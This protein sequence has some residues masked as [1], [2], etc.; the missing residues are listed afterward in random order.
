LPQAGHLAE[1]VPQA[2]HVT[3]VSPQLPPRIAT[4][5]RG[6]EPVQRAWAE[7]A[8]MDVANAPPQ[9]HRV[10][11]T[12]GQPL[13]HGVRSRFEGLLG[14][15]LTGVRVH[16][17]ESAA[18][19]ASAVGAKAFTVNHQVVFG[20]DQLRP[21]APA[22]NSLLAHEL[23][24][25]VQQRTA[26]PTARPV[27]QRQSDDDRAES[28]AREKAATQQRKQERAT[29]GKDFDQLTARDAENELRELEHS[30]QQPGAQQ[31][32]VARKDADLEQFRKLLTRVPGS[33]LEKSKRQGAFSELQRTP[34]T[35]AGTPQDKYVAGGPQTK[36]Q[37]LRAGRDS[38]AQP[39]WSLWR[40]RPDGSVERIHV[41]LKSDNLNSL[42]RGQARG[43][44]RAYLDQA[45][46]NS[47]HLADGEG[48]VIHFTQTPS[49]EIQA[50]MNAILFSAGSP[51][52]EVRYGTTT[53]YRPAPRAGTTSTTPS[54]A[55]PR[56][57][58]RAR[59]T[60]PKRAAKAA[61]AKKAATPKPKP[62]AATEKPATSR[63]A[64]AA[65][66]TTQ[67]PAKVAPAEPTAKAAKATTQE[68]AKVAPAEPTAKAAAHPSETQA[69]TPTQ[70]QSIQNSTET[71][72]PA[73]TP[74]K[75][76]P[77]VTPAPVQATET[78]TPTL[79]PETTEA[80]VGSPAPGIKAGGGLK[81][82][83]KAGGKALGWALLF[84]A[85][86]YEAWQ[87]REVAMEADRQ[88]ILLHIHGSSG[89]AT[90]M[91]KQDPSKPVYITWT[92][93][94]E[95]YVHYYPLLGFVPEPE[96][97]KLFI[98]GFTLG[99]TNIDPPSVEHHDNRTNVWRP[100][101]TTITKYSE[102]VI[103]AAGNA[104]EMP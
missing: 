5:A 80:P 3:R 32:S 100:G 75:G 36:D 102:L 55:S 96:D 42:T 45:V 76:A 66:A 14:H 89:A 101:E 103:D 2:D 19:A 61:P 48:I 6:A 78:K 60:T 68:P 50:E 10:L 17:D 93:R 95:D 40:R 35:T 25:V 58:K 41:N 24:H 69:V 15:D 79:H 4:R 62:A 73:A 65:K 39:D 26:G 85:L 37:E 21:H 72:Q 84:A 23:A 38:Y 22:G 34:T 97:R 67:E 20:A 104:V 16:S 51:I 94:L 46:R 57:A 53:H 52:T 44:A 29:A 33:S 63:P 27:L 31:R 74:A 92:V 13:D 98:A 88:Q 12:S 99:E 70:G 7:P 47:S 43:R 1:R 8:G 49:K 86:D 77:E 87:R 82:G 64:K 30:Y 28:R 56:D 11:R 81:A 90:R 71:G 9:V 59:A 91:Y 18:G 83:I 54:K